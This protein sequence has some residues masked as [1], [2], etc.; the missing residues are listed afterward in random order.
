M[1]F[2]LFAGTR[3]STRRWPCAAVSRG[4]RHQAR[5]RWH[6]DSTR[7]SWPAGWTGWPS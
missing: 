6:Y 5:A 1:I 2:T 7:P 3:W 4:R